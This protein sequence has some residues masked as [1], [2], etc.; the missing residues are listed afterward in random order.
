MINHF[1]GPNS[2]LNVVN[3]DHTLAY[4]KVASFETLEK[5][6]GEV[7]CPIKIKFENTQYDE[8]LTQKGAKLLT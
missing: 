5:N 8:T 4:N 7:F 1:F 2:K 6:D 3:A